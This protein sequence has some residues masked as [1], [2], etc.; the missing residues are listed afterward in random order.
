M[1]TTVGV[2]E[3]GSV[4]PRP[5]LRR[6]T[7]YIEQHMNEN[8]SL[9]RLGAVVCMSPYHFA[10]LFKRST[11]LS[12]HRFVVHTRIEHASALLTAADLSIR[13]ISQVVG[14]RT[15]SHFTTVFR[16]VTGTTPRAY[17]MLNRPVREGGRDAMPR[18][19]HRA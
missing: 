3:A 15:V 13:R 6:V 7:D 14:F 17:R 8:L 19:D 5:R 16:R 1:T 9:A 4:L 2:S 11:G 12:P 18:D 10:R